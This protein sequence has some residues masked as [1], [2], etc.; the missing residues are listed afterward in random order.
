[1]TTFVLRAALF[2]RHCN[3]ICLLRLITCTLRSRKIDTGRCGLH[4]L[5]SYLR[6]ANKHETVQSIISSQL[7]RGS[8][9]GLINSQ[10][11]F[12]AFSFYYKIFFDGTLHSWIFFPSFFLLRSLLL[13]IAARRWV[14]KGRI[15]FRKK[16][17]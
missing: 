7:H 11:S 6:L 17:P 1:L 9:Y 10:V 14:D 16:K 12:R 3:F 5:C 15:S 8:S 4:R 2:L 13:R